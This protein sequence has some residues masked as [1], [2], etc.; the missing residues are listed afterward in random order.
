MS[1]IRISKDLLQAAIEALG[2]T[3]PVYVAMQD[4]DG[5]I[6]ITT[7]NGTQTWTPRNS[8][9][10]PP[11]KRKKRTTTAPRKT[12]RKRSTSAGGG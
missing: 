6:L 3:V 10:K 11:A 7:R 1:D 4:E 9:Q 5:T 2:I 12:P 8:P